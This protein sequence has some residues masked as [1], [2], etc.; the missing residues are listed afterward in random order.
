MCV[1]G[2][3]RTRAVG[4]CLHLSFF[5]RLIAL[6]FSV[7]FPTQLVTVVKSQVL[8]AL[9]HLSVVSLD[10]STTM[11]FFEKMV[12]LMPFPEAVSQASLFLLNDCVD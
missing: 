5:R 6:V 8:V 4:S 1:G 10:D 11:S 2:G 7:Y 12:A 3:V 9:Y